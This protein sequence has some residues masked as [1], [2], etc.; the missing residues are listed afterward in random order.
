[1]KALFA[2]KKLIA[3]VWQCIAVD[4]KVSPKEEE[5]FKKVVAEYKNVTPEQV[6]KIKGLAARIAK[7]SDEEILDEYLTVRN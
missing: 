7:L 3:F 4:K 6:E 1:M 5:L 2:S